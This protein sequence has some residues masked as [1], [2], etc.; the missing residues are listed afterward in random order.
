MQLELKCSYLH[1]PESFSSELVRWHIPDLLGL[2]VLDR[3]VRFVGSFRGNMIASRR[4][5]VEI[6]WLVQGL[7][8]DQ[9]LLY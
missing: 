7:K 3:P 5:H 8:I 6:F 4:A 9:W 2:S 1:F